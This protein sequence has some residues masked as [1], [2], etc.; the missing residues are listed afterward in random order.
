MVLVPVVLVPGSS[1]FRLKLGASSSIHPDFLNLSNHET[2]DGH[3]SSTG[4]RGNHNTVDIPHKR[5]QV[6]RVYLRD[7]EALPLLPSHRQRALVH[8]LVHE[9][10]STQEVVAATHILLTQVQRKLAMRAVSQSDQR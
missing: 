10:G 9:Q 1:S 4:C 5:R 3:D 6:L 7:Q 8:T 2:R